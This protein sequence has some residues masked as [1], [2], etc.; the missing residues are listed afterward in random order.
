LC[1]LFNTYV[2]NDGSYSSIILANLADLSFGPLQWEDPQNT[3][4]GTDGEVYEIIINDL[5][6]AW[7][8]GAFSNAGITP[9]NYVP[10]VGYAMF[11][12][13]FSGQ[14]ATRSTLNPQLPLGSVVN[15]ISVS[16]TTPTNQ[17]IYGGTSSTSGAFAYSVVATNGTTTSL[18]L[19]NLPTTYVGGFNGL[20]YGLIAPGGVTNNYDILGVFDPSNLSSPT[21]F[22]CS[23]NLSTWTSFSDNPAN[24]GDTP[25]RATGQGLFFTNNSGTLYMN[26]A[27][28][29]TGNTY[30]K[31]YAS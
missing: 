29:S 9:S 20:A 6:H 22:W 18:S 17:L 1:G 13:T 27:N 16:G 24:N 14:P 7:V 23:N 30:F 21:K 8:V 5:A 28:N 31:Y 19:S 12:Y 15:G 2:A 25:T 26:A 10:A 4:F 3:E 11:V